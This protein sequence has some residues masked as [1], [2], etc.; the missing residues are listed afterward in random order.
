MFSF[1]QNATCF[2][3][4]DSEGFVLYNIDPFQI[5]DSHDIK[6]VHLV[7]ML[8]RSN[9]IAL[10]YR[11]KMDK[12]YM[13]DTKRKNE[14][15]NI[16]FKST[17]L[18][19]ALRRDLIVVCLHSNVYVHNFR[20]LKAIDRIETYPNPHGLISLAPG[21]HK[22]L[23]TLGRLKGHIRLEFYDTS[24]TST[25]N[26]HNN[27]IGAMILNEDATKLISTSIKG[28]I[29]R[30][31][32]TKHGS[33]LCEF[34]RGLEYVS[35]Y[36]L[37]IKDN[38]IA[39]TSNTGTIHIFKIDHKDHKI[40]LTNSYPYLNE[41]ASSYY[42]MLID[43]SYVIPTSITKYPTAIKDVRMICSFCLEPDT[44]NKL[45][46]ITDS[47]FFFNLIINDDGSIFQ[48]SSFQMS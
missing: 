3:R 24:K 12:L 21:S 9:I 10:V 36:S 27:E 17:I 11:D 29:I 45:H 38:F 18:K 20:D 4:I 16:S 25:I 7:E 19:V 22:V 1:N 26:A 35:I 47:G 23:A 33:K 44:Q 42:N 15:G 6:N 40:N 48:E 14:I 46:V 31:F 37:S 32:D 28:T 13:W 30:V 41:K 2:S 43:K 5:M 39:S 34:R 8:Y